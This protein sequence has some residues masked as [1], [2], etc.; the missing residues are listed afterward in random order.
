MNRYADLERAPSPENGGGAPIPSPAPESSPETERT[1]PADR[2]CEG[3]NAPLVDRR[4][5][6]RH[7]SDR[8][9]TRAHRDRQF[10]RV[11]ELLDAIAGAVARLRTELDLPGDTADVKRAQ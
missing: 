10:G 7:C 2:L 8:C 1:V 3:C 4:P 5:Q 11:V 6:A 9:R